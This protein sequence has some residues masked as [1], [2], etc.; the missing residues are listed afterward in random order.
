[1]NGISPSIAFTVE[2][3]CDGNLPF[4]DALVTQNIGGR[5]MQKT[6]AHRQVPFMSH[7]PLNVK[8]GVIQCLVKRAEEVTTNEDLK[9]NEMRHLVVGLRGN[10]Y[11]LNMR[12]GEK[13]ESPTMMM[14]KK[15]RNR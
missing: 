4:L 2:Q 11:P 12:Q 3:E 15:N 9:K 1:M 5:C 8:R 7:Y 6:N 14:R 13:N 10:G